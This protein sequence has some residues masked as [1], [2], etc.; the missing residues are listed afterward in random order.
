M[1]VPDL[2][3]QLGGPY[4]RDGIRALEQLANGARAAAPAAIPVAAVAGA[5]AAAPVLIVVGA[6]IAVPAAIF[7]VNKFFS[8]GPPTPEEWRRVIQGIEV[9]T[10]IFRSFLRELRDGEDH[11]VHSVPNPQGLLEADLAQTRRTVAVHEL[12]RRGHHNRVHGRLVGA[13]ARLAGEQAGLATATGILADRTADA[14]RQLWAHELPQLRHHMRDLIQEER[15]ARSNGDTQL[16]QRLQ[17]RVQELRSRI[18]DVVRWLQTEAIPELEE[19]VSRETALRISADQRLRRGLS[20][21]VGARTGADAMLMAQLAPL[22]QW[23]DG[24]GKHTTEKVKRNEDLMDRFNRA[25]LG[26]LNQLILAG[27]FVTLVTEIGARVAP[28]LPGMLEALEA[29]A[30]RAI[31][32][33]F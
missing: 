7:V 1:A 30:T 19:L 23:A 21:E 28:A 9:I 17:A 18:G 11:A 31:G 29:R 10:S 32:E 6:V 27:P 20:E 26:F 24:F 33:V 22:V 25:D 4:V 5:S 14:F 2:I 16:A 3:E 8:P 15:E 12:W 13:E